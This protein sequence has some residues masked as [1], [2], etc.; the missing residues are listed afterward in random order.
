[1]FSSPLELRRRIAA[2]NS[3]MAV[4]LFCGSLVAASDRRPSLSTIHP[5]TIRLLKNSLADV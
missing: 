3:Q 1:M 2:T 4:H 5:F